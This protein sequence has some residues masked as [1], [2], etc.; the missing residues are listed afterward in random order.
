MWMV[1]NG[2]REYTKQNYKYLPTGFGPYVICHCD[3]LVVRSQGV[4]QNFFEDNYIFRKG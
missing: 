4:F 2:L 3:C 1:D